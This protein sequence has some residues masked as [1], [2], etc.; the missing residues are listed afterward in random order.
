M[1]WCLFPGLRIENEILVP[2]QCNDNDCETVRAASRA[3]VKSVKQTVDFDYQ[4]DLLIQLERYLLGEEPTPWIS[5]REP[6]GPRESFDTST[7]TSK[8]I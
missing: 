2:G 8:G 7:P 6:L 5:G 1:P 4:R 3:A